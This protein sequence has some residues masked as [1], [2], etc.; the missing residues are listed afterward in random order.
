MKKLFIIILAIAMATFAVGCNG[1]T[2]IPDRLTLESDNWPDFF[3][4][5]SNEEI[6][7]FARSFAVVATDDTLTYDCLGHFEIIDVGGQIGGM[8]TLFLFMLRDDGYFAFVY[9]QGDDV[10]RLNIHRMDLMLDDTGEAMNFWHLSPNV[11]IKI[12]DD[13]IIE[14]TQIAVDAFSGM[15]PNY[16]HIR[17]TYD[18]FNTETRMNAPIAFSNISNYAIRDDGFSQITWKITENSEDGAVDYMALGLIYDGDALAGAI[19]AP[20]VTISTL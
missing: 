20:G 5:H 12:P 7:Q 17:V 13:D 18:L 10:D 14:R 16:N 8:E 19:L 2:D 4:S 6:V 11:S 9:N 1:G 15:L 3:Q